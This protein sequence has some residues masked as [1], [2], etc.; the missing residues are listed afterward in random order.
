M[1][2]SLKENGLTFM[3]TA[4]IQRKYTSNYCPYDNDPEAILHRNICFLCEM[5]R[6]SMSLGDRTLLNHV[7]SKTRPTIK[8]FEFKIIC[9][10][11]DLED[12]VLCV[13]MWHFEGGKKIADLWTHNENWTR[14]Q[15]IE[16]ISEEA[17]LF[18]FSFEILP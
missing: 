7:K 14:R 18:G 3:R 10:P 13:Q 11:I 9:S 5:P 8:H 4:T 17:V 12:L 2:P 6:T 16:V 1:P 15:V